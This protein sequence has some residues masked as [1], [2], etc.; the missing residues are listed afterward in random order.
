MKYTDIW[1]VSKKFQGT[2]RFSV[3][4]GCILKNVN[5]RKTW[6]MFRKIGNI[7]GNF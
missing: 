6:V 3:N 5:V 2:E 7:F 1:V 4:L